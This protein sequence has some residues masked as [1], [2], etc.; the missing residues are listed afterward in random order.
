[1]KHKKKPESD[2]PTKDGADAKA[3]PDK[4]AEPAP[5]SAE[6]PPAKRDLVQLNFITQRGVILLNVDPSMAPNDLR[7]RPLTE[8]A[9]AIVRSGNIPLIDSIRIVSPRMFGD[10]AKTLPPRQT[11]PSVVTLLPPGE[12]ATAVAAQLM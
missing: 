7:E 2:G 9:R 6:K 4:P 11:E 8:A 12:L 5:D 3:P 10:F 1:S